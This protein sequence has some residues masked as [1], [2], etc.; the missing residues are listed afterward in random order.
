MGSHL[1]LDI[2]S[3]IL[4]V[5]MATVVCRCRG[6]HGNSS[7]LTQPLQPSWCYYTTVVG[8]YLDCYGLSSLFRYPLQ[9]P[10]CFYSNDVLQQ[11]SRLLLT[12]NFS[13]DIHSS[14]LGIATATVVRRY[15]CCHGHGLRL[16]LDVNF[17]FLSVTIATAVRSLSKLP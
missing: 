9:P 5:A 12:F 7:P 17:S 15:Q 2:H 1:P 11:W 16:P 8:R 13:W 6:C 10:R 4:G 14:F 3:S